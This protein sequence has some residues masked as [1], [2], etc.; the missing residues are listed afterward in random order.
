[1]IENLAK[2]TSEIKTSANEINK[3]SDEVSGKKIDSDKRIGA[4]KNNIDYS[5][6]LD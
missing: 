2:P 5:H 1:M 3:K 4:A 6:D